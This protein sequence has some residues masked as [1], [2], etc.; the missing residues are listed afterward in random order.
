MFYTILADAILAIHLAYV[1]YVVLGQILIMVGW[2]RG[3]K[4]IRNFWFRASHLAMIVVVALESIGGVTCPLTTWE[5]NLRE[6]AGQSIEQAS[7]VA[8]LMSSIMFFDCSQQEKIFTVVYVAFA[9]MVIATFIFIPPRRRK[10]KD[11]Q[12]SSPERIVA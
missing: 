1:S 5:D 4:W 9:L 8:R 10:A 6:M 12:P 2:W 11:D 3:W 7:F